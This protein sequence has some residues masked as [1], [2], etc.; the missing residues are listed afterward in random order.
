MVAQV[1]LLFEQKFRRWNCGRRVLSVRD[2][3]CKRWRVV[4]VV[5]EQVFYYREDASES[6]IREQGAGK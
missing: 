5:T 1:R 2:A 4:F 6:R 3:V